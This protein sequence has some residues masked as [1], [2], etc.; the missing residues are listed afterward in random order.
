MEYR[1]AV[2]NFAAALAM[3]TLAGCGSQSG[4]PADAKTADSGAKSPA[5]A[6]TQNAGKDGPARAVHDFLEAVRTGNDSKAAIMLTPV[7]RR[8][9][10]E[11]QMTV[12]P[13]G[14]DTAKF[15]IGEVEFVQE[16]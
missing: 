8:K 3:M 1:C 5:A 10:E 14:S 2:H 15:E 12:A 4:P 11:M 7:A 13:P 6:T 16:G 9:T